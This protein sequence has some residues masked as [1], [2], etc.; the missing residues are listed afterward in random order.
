MLER[1]VH[2]QLTCHLKKHHPLPDVQSA[3]RKGFTTTTAVLKV[4]SDIIATIL[5]EKGVLLSL[6]EFTAA[7]DKVDHDILLQHLEKMF[8]FSGLLLKWIRSYLS[9]QMQNM[10]WYLNGKINVACPVICGMLQGPFLGQLL[11]TLYTAN[12]GEI[13]D[14]KDLNIIRMLMTIRCIHLVLIRCRCL[15]RQNS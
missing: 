8:S 9:N 6:L 14:L 15:M 10:Y 13:I 4:C 2:R 1:I 12:I 3:Y 7:F 11:F 5:N